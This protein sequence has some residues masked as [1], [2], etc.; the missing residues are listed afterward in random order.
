M[1]SVRIKQALCS[2]PVRLTAIAVVGAVFAL[3]VGASQARPAGG[4]QVT[5]SM[6]AISGTQPSW[7]VL[8][9]NFE[10]VHP[11]ITVNPTYMSQTMAY[12]QE[13]IELAAGN[14]PDLLATFPGGCST[15][16]SICVLAKA[17][18]LAPM[19]KAP[20][21]RR[22]LRYVISL[23]KDGPALYG[24]LP[25]LAPIG[26]FT[27]DDLFRRLGLKVPQTF[28]Q[29]LALCQQAKADGTVA[30]DFAAAGDPTGFTWLVMTLAVADVYAENKNWPSELKA[31][32]V[33]FEGTPGWHEA[34]EQVIE[35]DNAGCFEPGASGTT[36]ASLFLQGQSLMTTPVTSGVKGS[37]D[38]ASPP[39]SPTFHPFP[40]GATAGQTPIM[41]AMGTEL[42]VNAD[43]SPA[44]QAAAQ[45]FIDF[46]A[47]P[48]QDALYANTK[49][50]LTQYQFLHDQV[51]PFM[52]SIAPLLAAHE[53]VISPSQTWWNPNV[54]LALQQDELGLLTDQST[55]DSILTAM[56]A[57][58]QQG[59][60]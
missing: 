57:A 53:Y 48:A 44:N 60:A 29:L 16:I 59:P 36:D 47:R 50:S 1:R 43:S 52:S 14:A 35:M 58:W 24:F 3:G 10:A 20:W 46:V 32:K 19:I 28:P 5:I 8:I 33:T 26:V 51:Q 9:P 27:N 37:I 7:N 11:N 18:Y 49:G 17:G 55:P 54:L 31:G 38:A 2:P 21:T 22:S 12:Q 34:L 56:D 30:L 42:S 40:A 13:T 45:T 41:V 23:S 39:F 6:L 25:S 15:P 4:G